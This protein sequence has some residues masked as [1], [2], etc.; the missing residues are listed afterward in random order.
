MSVKLT[1]NLLGYRAGTDGLLIY[2][3]SGDKSATIRM[4]DGR[5]LYLHS[6]E[7]TII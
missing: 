5:I 7:Y 1:T 4:R 3:D 2:Q 6:Y